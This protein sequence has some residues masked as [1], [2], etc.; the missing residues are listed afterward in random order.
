MIQSDVNNAPL[1][2]NAPIIEISWIGIRKINEI[3]AII[4]QVKI[5]FQDRVENGYRCRDT[6]PMTVGELIMQLLILLNADK[7]V[8]ESI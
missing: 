7:S 4:L 6:V 1:I 8:R 3:R 2:L 5:Y